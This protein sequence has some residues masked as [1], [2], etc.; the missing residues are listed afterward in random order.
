MLWY[1]LTSTQGQGVWQL[2]GHIPWYL[3]TN[4]EGQGVWEQYCHTLWKCYI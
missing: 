1:L 3:L 2:K 4:T